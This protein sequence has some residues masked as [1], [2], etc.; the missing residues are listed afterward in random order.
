MIYVITNGK[1]F[2]KT[3]NK[4]T[5]HIHEAKTFPNIKTA[6]VCKKNMKRTFKKMGEWIITPF[7]TARNPPTTDFTNSKVTSKITVEDTATSLILANNIADNYKKVMQYKLQ[8]EQDIQQSEKETQDILHFVEF[9]DLN[10]SQGYNIYKTLQNIRL[11]RRKAKDELAR[12]N[13]FL[14]LSAEQMPNYQ[15]SGT[16]K[17]SYVPR[18]LPELFSANYKKHSE[19]ET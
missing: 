19:E 15:S 13:H 12:I 10:A 2:I 18:A 17:K 11:K 14:K 3:T 9:Y 5:H 8:L 1:H 16:E 4:L 6:E 7:E